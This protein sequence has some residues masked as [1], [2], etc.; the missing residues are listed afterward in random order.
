MGHSAINADIESLYRRSFSH[1]LLYVTF[2]SP[3]CSER[4]SSRRVSMRTDSIARNIIFGAGVE[5]TALICARHLRVR[6]TARQIWRYRNPGSPIPWKSSDLAKWFASRLHGGVAFTKDQSIRRRWSYDIS[7]LYTNTHMHIHSLS[8]FLL[9]CFSLFLFSFS[10]SLS[11]A[12]FSRYQLSI[13]VHPF[14]RLSCPFCRPHLFH[15]SSS[16]PRFPSIRFILKTVVL[17]SLV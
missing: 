16:V 11:F 4:W 7:T 3:A 6:S 1:N 13:P 14:P 10:F 17:S 15:L 9:H 2:R 5:S 12:T 8:F